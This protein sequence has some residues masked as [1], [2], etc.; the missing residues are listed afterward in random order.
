MYRK[1]QRAV[2]FLACLVLT[3]TRLNVCVPE[4]FVCYNT[5]IPQGDDGIMKRW[6]PLGDDLV[7]RVQPSCMILMPL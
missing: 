3:S 1:L 4:R 2:G 6:G 5:P 7:L